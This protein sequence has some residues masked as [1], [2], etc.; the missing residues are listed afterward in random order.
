MSPAKQKKIYQVA[1]ELN[2][3]SPAI[4]EFLEDRGFEVSKTPKHM[5]PMT[6]DMYDEVLKKFD[7]SRWQEMQ[8]ATQTPEELREEAERSRTEQL[9]ELLNT[10]SNQTLDSAASLIRQVEAEEEKRQRERMAEQNREREQQEAEERAR[11]AEIDKQKLEAEAREQ[12]ERAEIEKRRKEIEAQRAADEARRQARS[13]AAKSRTE[14]RPPRSTEGR[15]ERKSGAPGTQ[16]RR[17][18]PQAGEGTHRPRPGAAAAPAPA[19]TT[20]AARTADAKKRRAP[21]KADIERIEK[22]KR[23]IAAQKQEKAKRVPPAVEG[24]SRRTKTKTKRKEVN[25][26]EVQASIRQTLASMDS[27]KRRAKRRDKITGELVETQDNVLQLTEFVS[28]QELANLMD[29]PVAEVIKKFFM[30]GK[31][32]TINQRLEH[33]LIELMAD[34]FGF[35]V[36]FVTDQEEVVQDLEEEKDDPEDLEARPPVVTVMGH[37]DHGKTSLLDYL[38]KTTVIAEEHGGITQHIGAY[39]VVHKG[40]KVTF[41]DTPGHEAFTAMRARGAQVTDLVILVISADDQVRPQTLEAISHAQSAN[42]PIIVAINKIDRPNADPEKIRKQLAEHNLLVEQ[43]G[44]KIQSAEISAKFGQGID[45]LLE[46]VLLAADILELKGNPN[47]RARATVVET[48]M[49]KG[50][51]VVATLI[52]TNGTLAVG[53]F[54]VA[55]QYHGKVRTLLDEHS[56]S[57]DNVGPGRPAQVVGFSGA[58]QAGDTFVCFDSEREV[59]DIAMRRQLLQRE[60]TFRQIRML[61]LD[62]LSQRIREGEIRELPLI[63]KGD[64]DG[65]VEAI[66]DQLQRL[67]TKEVGVKIVHRGVGAIS[68][69]DVLLAAATGAIILGFHVHPNLKAREYAM[70]E[71]VDIRVYRII[72]EM[73]NDIRTALEGMLRPDT[74]EDV[75]GLIEVRQTFHVPSSGTIA[76][77]FVVSGSI[78]R[79][80]QIRLLRDGKQIWSGTIGSLRRFKN[81]VTEVKSG[82][83]CGI[84]L[85]NMNDVR[86]GDSIEVISIVEVKRTLEQSHT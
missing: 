5:S 80:S 24:R 23:L 13:E 14:S 61:S 20:D 37:V 2:V 56:R 34:E 84:L 74:R 21:S 19:E 41:L 32:V 83:E 36:E 31:L 33:D 65:S 15:P 76:G 79:N 8:S 69:S 29:V 26:A 70:R 75:I 1:K 11:Q 59:K 77:C 46:E 47:R 54:F 10:A 82:Y 72:Y 39:E 67:S 60:Q 73:E 55:G 52:V 63:I 27:G 22:Q 12:K 17:P 66:C 43:W 57:I 7:P 9:D 6:E 38:R 18:A 45:N 78:K 68:E 25:V 71:S 16:T 50:R 64:A 40:R 48:R 4:V 62:Q 85:A 28:T 58:P 35:R 51:G 42:V 86:E 44:G 49:E 81:D 53:D 3:A 30:M